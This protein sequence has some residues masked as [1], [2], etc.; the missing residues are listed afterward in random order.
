MFVFDDNSKSFCR[1]LIVVTNRREPT[2][3]R[4]RQLVDS[5]ISGAIRLLR[6]APP[7]TITTALLAEE[8]GCSVA[9]MYRFFTDKES[10]FDAAAGRLQEQLRARYTTVLAALPPSATIDETVDALLDVT[11]A[12]LRKEPA[13]RALR[14]KNAARTVE[15][16]RVYKESNRFLADRLHERF[17]G[18]AKGTRHAFDSAVEAAGHLVGVAF[19][20]NAK[21]DPQILD[22][23]RVM[24]KLFLADALRPATARRELS[25]SRVI[26][27]EI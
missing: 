11:A 10:I 16:E 8:A 4:S 19:E 14:W 24:A 12:F 6:T 21:G 15:V 3:E 2:Q 22:N 13:F 17:G 23:A 20:H 18:S 26:P 5:V 7:D 1:R 9:A 27:S 25:V